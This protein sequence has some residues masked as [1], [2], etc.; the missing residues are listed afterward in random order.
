MLELCK[1]ELEALNKITDASEFLQHLSENYVSYK[2]EKVIY[3]EDD[4]KSGKI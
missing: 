2:N 1:S 4:L 3:T